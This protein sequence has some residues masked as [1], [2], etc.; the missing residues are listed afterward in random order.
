MSSDDATAGPITGFSHV[1]LLCT[2]VAASEQWY[3]TVLGAEVMTAADDRSYVAL[4]HRPSGAVLVL[5]TRPEGTPET[6]P[7][8]HLAFGV[9]DG[10]TLEQWAAHL[11]ERGIAHDGIVLEL[12]KPSLQLLD[13]DG[14]EIELVAPPPR[15]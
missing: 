6:G 4:R 8:D 13:P 2:D 14:I 10:D 5:S 9:P 11:T 1:Q 15:S 7:L 12:G 3:T